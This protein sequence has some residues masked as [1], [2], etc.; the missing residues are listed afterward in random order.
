MANGELKATIHSSSVTSTVVTF[1]GTKLPNLSSET[2]G[3]DAKQVGQTAT[4]EHGVDRQLRRVSTLSCRFAVRFLFSRQ[5][6]MNIYD[7]MHPSASTAKLT[8]V[9]LSVDP[10]SS[11]EC[12]QGKDSKVLHFDL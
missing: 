12:E 6:K 11:A 4:Y 10:C 9:V 2:A 3:K 1:F 7:G 8:V 5:Y